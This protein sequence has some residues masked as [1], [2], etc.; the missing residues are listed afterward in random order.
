[1]MN[2]SSQLQGRQTV[3][4][5]QVIDD[6]QTVRCPNETTI[7]KAANTSVILSF[8]TMHVNY[9]APVLHYDRNRFN[10]ALMPLFSTSC[11]V[12][13]MWDKSLSRDLSASR[14]LSNFYNIL[15]ENCICNCMIGVYSAFHVLYHQYSEVISVYLYSDFNIMI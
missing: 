3:S 6:E 15:C 10:L 8:N 4:Y 11:R 14:I 5:H 13:I 7:G 2:E 9:S 1:M 12:P